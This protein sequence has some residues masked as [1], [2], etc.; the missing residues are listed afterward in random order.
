MNVS[1]K[2][3]SGLAYTSPLNPNSSSILPSGLDA[4]DVAALFNATRQGMKIKATSKTNE[5]F[6]LWKIAPR[7]DQQTLRE[8][9]VT[10]KVFRIGD[11]VENLNTGLV[12]RIIRRG[13]NHL[14]CLTQEE[15]MFKSWEKD[16]MEYTEV[17]MKSRMRD[18]NHPNMLV[19][20]TGYRKNAQASVAGQEKI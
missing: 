20:T 8:N 17:K 9:Y 7:Y 4:G 15:N 12:G 13:A 2:Y 19:G 6:A 1:P 18:K 10:K 14:I 11:L 3:S 16:V 5:D